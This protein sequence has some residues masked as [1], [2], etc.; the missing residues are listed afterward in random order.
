[1]PGQGQGPDA[2]TDYYSLGSPWRVPKRAPE[3]LIQ[4]TT[5]GY[6]AT[7]PLTSVSRIL[8]SLRKGGVAPQNIVF[9]KMSM[10]G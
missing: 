3:L 5:T 4:T 9:C 10:A 7:P 1:M 8:S 6:L 2:Y